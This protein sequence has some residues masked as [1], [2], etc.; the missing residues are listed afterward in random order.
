MQK[1][2]NAI[3]WLIQHERSA[4]P[5]HLIWDTKTRAGSRGDRANSHYWI[6]QKTAKG[7]IEISVRDN[8]FSIVEAQGDFRIWI[9]PKIIDVTRPVV[10]QKGK[11]ILFSRKVVPVLRVVARS[12]LEYNDPERIYVASIKVSVSGSP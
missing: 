2:S 5:T 1:D 8:A 11:D 4:H 6:E 3:R 7:T 10:V 12:I 9:D